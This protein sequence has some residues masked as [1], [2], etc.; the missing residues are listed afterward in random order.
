MAKVHTKE[1]AEAVL[2]ELPSVV[3]A[4]VRED[5]YGHPREVHLLVAPGPDTRLLAH[6][7]RDLLQ[8]RLGVPVD[9]RVISIA[10]LSE[11]PD[12]PEA[13]VFGEEPDPEEA[14]RAEEYSDVDPRLR[15]SALE[16]QTR[17]GRIVVRVRLEWRSQTITGEAIEMD[18]GTGRLRATAAAALHAAGIACRGR[19]R[20]Q[21][22]SAST[23]R[24]FSRDYVITVVHTSAPALG[25]RPM[26]LTGAHPIEDDPDHAA[27]LA[28]LKA[29]N[30][31]AGHWLE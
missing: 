8:E 13:P 31:V 10:Q 23:V 7:I 17:D 28:A 24:A 18:A 27:A 2:R 16:M 4:F 11:A 15:F 22:E 19:L 20:F 3:G 6:D 12:E 1:T 26:M 30:R 9:Q 5:V 29:I 21:L 14:T 25:R